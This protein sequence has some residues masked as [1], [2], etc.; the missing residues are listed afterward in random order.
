MASIRLI[1][2]DDLLADIDTARVGPRLAWI[3]GAIAD[4]LGSPGTTAP[5]GSRIA[6]AP[7]RLPTPPR[8]MTRQGTLP[9]GSVCAH[10]FRNDAGYCPNCGHRP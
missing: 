10:P 6:G 7:G 9:D 1:L 2:P 5:S 8:T 4:K 3:R